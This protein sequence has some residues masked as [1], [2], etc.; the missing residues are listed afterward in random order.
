M[1]K[2]T[3]VLSVRF[4]SHYAQYLEFDDSTNVGTSLG[5]DAYVSQISQNQ[6]KPMAMT[7]HITL[8]TIPGIR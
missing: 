3:V 7:V 4:R 5:A 2:D 1:G 8:R 6:V